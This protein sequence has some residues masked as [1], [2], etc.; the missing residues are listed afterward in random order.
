MIDTGYITSTPTPYFFEIEGGIVFC[1]NDGI[2]YRW[3]G[4][5]FTE[6]EFVGTNPEP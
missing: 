4:D 5:K 2:V 3:S 1:V 6:V